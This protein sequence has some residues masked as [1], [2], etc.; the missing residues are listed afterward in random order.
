MSTSLDKVFEGLTFRVML[1]FF[2]AICC[3]IG[4]CTGRILWKIVMVT[5]D[6]LPLPLEWSEMI[7][8]VARKVTHFVFLD[9]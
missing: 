6:L 3:K 4:Y 2:L 7:Y 9:M 1:C 5:L 8:D